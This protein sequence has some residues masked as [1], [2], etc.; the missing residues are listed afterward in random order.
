VAPSEPDDPD[1]DAP[2]VAKPPSHDANLAVSGGAVPGAAVGVVAVLG[3]IV[4]GNP[5]C[6]RQRSSGS[7]RTMR[8]S[9][10]DAIGTMKVN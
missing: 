2:A 10:C 6:P 7:S 9:G 8:S 5:S 4:S 3:R 1:V